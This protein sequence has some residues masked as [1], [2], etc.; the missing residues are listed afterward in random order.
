VVRE[1]GRPV[2]V[3]VADCVPIALTGPGLAGAVHA[4]WRGLCRG[5]I[6]AAAVAAGPGACAWI[7]P[8]IGPCCFEVGPEVPAE[9]AA[10]HPDVPDCSEVVDGTLRFDLR[11]A[12]AFALR[13][14]GV[15]VAEAMGIPC[16]SC[17]PRFFSYRRDGPTTGRQALVTWR[18]P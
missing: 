10:G 7:G 9:F 4:G 8:C 15:G 12:A 18:E 5:V 11:R 2:A 14:A 1:K 6:E 17:D 16:T 13:A 3:L